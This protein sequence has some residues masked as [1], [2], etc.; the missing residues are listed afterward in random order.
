MSI[1]VA[2]SRSERAEK[3]SEFSDKSSEISDAMRLV[4]IAAEPRPVGDSVKGA[5]RRAAS[6]LSWSQSRTR[7]VW[8]G[9]VRRIDSHEMD[10]LRSIERR[11]NLR[12]LES[13]YRKHIEQLAALR[14][15]L[16][17]RDAEFH[18]ADTEAITFLLD[19]LQ[20]SLRR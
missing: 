8:Y 19:E 11:Q 18:K 20:V 10:A 4:R 9:E 17:S 15:R 5:I 1:S 16:Q 3:P 13:N 7:D 14:A 12:F 2:I 6:V